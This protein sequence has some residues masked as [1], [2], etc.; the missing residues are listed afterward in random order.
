MGIKPE[1]SRIPRVLLGRMSMSYKELIKG[2]RTKGA[3]MKAARKKSRS[4]LGKPIL[5]VI[6]KDRKRTKMHAAKG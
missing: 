2:I 5:L 3:P 4:I 1:T 6:M